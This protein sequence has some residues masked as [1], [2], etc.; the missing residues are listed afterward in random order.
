MDGPQPVLDRFVRSDEKPLDPVLLEEGQV[1]VLSRTVVVG[2][3]DEH[4]QPFGGRPL[5]DPFRD[6]PEERVG[7]VGDEVG[8][9]RTT[10]H[11]QLRG[12]VVAD[13]PQLVDRALDPD[14]QLRR[15]PARM[16][17]VVRH[18]PLRDSRQVGDVANAHPSHLR[19]LSREP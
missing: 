15:H 16:V 12:H 3:D 8:D 11:P 4:R 13:E 14:L 2:V 19:D 18:A 17:Q 10:A 6:G 5:L 1:V 7:H 9:R